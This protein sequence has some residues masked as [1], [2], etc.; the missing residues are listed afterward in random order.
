MV[1]KNII[2][3]MVESSLIFEEK[4]LVIYDFVEIIDFIKI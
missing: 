4:C 2:W 1:M 3:R